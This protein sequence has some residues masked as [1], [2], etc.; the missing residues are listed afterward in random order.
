MLFNVTCH[1]WQSGET[2][3]ERKVVRKD[4]PEKHVD[5]PKHVDRNNTNTA[6]FALAS[7]FERIEA[8]N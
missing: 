5:D 1:V 6:F 4:R 2:P 8:I 3:Q 7:L